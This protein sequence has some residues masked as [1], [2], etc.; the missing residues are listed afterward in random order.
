[1][2]IRGELEGCVLVTCTEC[3]ARLLPD[4]VP[5]RPGSKLSCCWHYI[6][7]CLAFATGEGSCLVMLLD[8]LHSVSEGLASRQTP[9]LQSLTFSSS[10]GPSRFCAQRMLLAG[11][12]PGIPSFVQPFLIIAQHTPGFMLPL[13]VAHSPDIC[14]RR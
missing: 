10:Q 2:W 7:H 11:C 5:L 1:M 8:A 12:R 13:P 4:G 3:S 9:L 14:A 6:V